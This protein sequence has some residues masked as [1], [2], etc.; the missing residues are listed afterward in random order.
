MV[1]STSTAA[2]NNFSGV[3]EVDG[4]FDYHH[5]QLLLFFRS[6]QTYQPTPVV[7]N[8]YHCL[9]LTPLSATM[10]SCNCNSIIV[11]NSQAVTLFSVVQ[12]NSCQLARKLCQCS[13]SITKCII[14][15]KLLIKQTLSSTT[16]GGY[17]GG[18][19][20]FKDTNCFL[21]NLNSSQENENEHIVG[22]FVPVV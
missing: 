7:N 16:S 8:K 1:T 11:N 5:C 13:R 18:L 21:N 19:F 6:T 12:V 22:S 3:A 10:A 9:L 4:R 20:T 14:T 15:T 17:C 2:D